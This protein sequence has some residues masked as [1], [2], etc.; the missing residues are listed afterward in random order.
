MRSNLQQME[1]SG[2][3]NAFEGPFCCDKHERGLLKNFSKS[4]GKWL[5]C[6]IFYFRIASVLVTVTSGVNNAMVLNAI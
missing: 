6:G 3:S 4:R 5:A 1:E 2:L